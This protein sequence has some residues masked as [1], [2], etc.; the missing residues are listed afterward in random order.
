M[1][2]RHAT[3]PERKAIRELCD[4]VG[5]VEIL[6]VIGSI[7]SNDHPDITM[8]QAYARKLLA[9]ASELNADRAGLDDPPSQHN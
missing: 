5:P 8:G 1:N 4:N 3:Q 7:I 9:I 6:R 2:Y